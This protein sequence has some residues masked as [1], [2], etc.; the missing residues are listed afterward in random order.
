MGHRAIDKEMVDLAKNNGLDVWAWTVND[1][2]ETK[3]L[4]NLGVNN[5]TTDRPKWLKEQVGN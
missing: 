4:V 2:K 5:I 1:P 3:R